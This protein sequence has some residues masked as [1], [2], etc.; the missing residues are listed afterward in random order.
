[1]CAGSSPT[2]FTGPATNVLYPLQAAGSPPLACLAS[3][4]RNSILG[5]VGKSWGKDGKIWFTDTPNS[6]IGSFD[7]KTE[8]FE[9]IQLPQFNLV[10]KK[11][12]PTSVGVDEENDDLTAAFVTWSPKSSAFPRVLISIYS[13]VL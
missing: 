12:L 4:W 8:Q 5:Q 3:E 1:M 7:P 9:T 2:S 6:K 13:I 11:S 10:T